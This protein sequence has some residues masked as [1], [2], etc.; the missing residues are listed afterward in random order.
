MMEK[1]FSISDIIQKRV[2]VLTKKEQIIT[3]TLILY[4]MN[5]KTIAL[6]DY[7]ILVK[8]EE[9]KYEVEDEGKL[10]LIK[11]DGWVIIKTKE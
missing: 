6:K 3:G 11:H 10:I 8:N 1:N 7:Q 4:G 2:S 5:D 9:G